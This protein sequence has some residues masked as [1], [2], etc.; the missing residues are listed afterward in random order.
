M[1]IHRAPEDVA[2]R[3]LR[4]KLRF[5]LSRAVERRAAAI[6]RSLERIA[7]TTIQVDKPHGGPVENHAEMRRMTAAEAHLMGIWF[8][9]YF[10][11]DCR[12]VDFLS[13]TAA[14][15]R[16]HIAEL[17]EIAERIEAAAKR[18]RKTS[19]PGRK[20]ERVSA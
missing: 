16:E 8:T 19:R 4:R 10:E 1:Q 12:N 17:A 18:R 3:E 2:K 9:D 13:Q 11:L 7:G 14:Q 20:A 5:P 15:L 6:A